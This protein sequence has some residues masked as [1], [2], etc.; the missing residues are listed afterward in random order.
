[1]Q[2]TVKSEKNPEMYADFVMTI[3]NSH[4][5]TKVVLA[6]VLIVHSWIQAKFV[7]KLL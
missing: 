4:G 7:L 6:F 5:D 2:S 1:M 3:V